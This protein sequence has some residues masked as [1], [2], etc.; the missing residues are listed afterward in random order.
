[1]PHSVTFKLTTSTTTLHMILKC[2]RLAF[3]SGLPH[4]LLLSLLL[5]LPLADY[6]DD[7]DDGFGR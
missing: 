4:L 2:D 3:W 7:D 5:L 6:D 1:M